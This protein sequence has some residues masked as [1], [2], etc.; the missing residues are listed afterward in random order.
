MSIGPIQA[1]VVGFPTT[2][3]FEGRVADELA[4]LS[5]LGLIRIIN[6]VFVMRD[7]GEAV[8]LQV[9]DLDDEQREMLGAAMGAVVG[10]VAAG[11]E[12]LEAGAVAGIDA[13]AGTGIAGV[14]AEDILAELPDDTAALV[15]VVEH[16]WLI[17]LRDALRDAG[18]ILLARQALGLEELAAL[19]VSIAE[20]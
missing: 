8:L 18:G 20:D 2:D 16:R 17:P 19:G 5:D 3:R 12:G 14:L 15:L 11:E 6:A 9:S 1:I 10:F 4:R 7:E 13:T